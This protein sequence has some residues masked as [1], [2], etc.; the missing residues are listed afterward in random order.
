[1][2]PVS[3]FSLDD[4]RPRGH[5][6]VGLRFPTGLAGRRVERDEI[7]VRGSVE[8][9]IVVDRERLG[10]RRRGRVA[11]VFPEQIAAGRI[12]R[13]DN[14]ARTSSRCTPRYTIG[15]PSNVPVGVTFVHAALSWP[16]FCL[17]IW[18]ND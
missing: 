12:E 16:T 14:R 7:A 2:R 17:V 1:V 11:L 5:P 15:M 13:P 18:F 4:N 9:E 8:N 6:A 10:S 3:T